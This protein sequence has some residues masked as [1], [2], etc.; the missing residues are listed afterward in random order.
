[1]LF[2][3]L[4]RAGAGR[5]SWPECFGLT[6]DREAEVSFAAS[7]PRRQGGIVTALKPARSFGGVR[8]GE[9]LLGQ[10]GRGHG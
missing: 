4:V 10:P 1:M 6:R 7:V 9:R 2:P 5:D 8:F 3:T